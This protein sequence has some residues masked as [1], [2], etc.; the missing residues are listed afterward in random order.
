MRPETPTTAL[1]VQPL[2]AGATAPMTLTFA[3][4]TGSA[5]GAPLGIDYIG[6]A[7]DNLSSVAPKRVLNANIGTTC[8]VVNNCPVTIN[9][10]ATREGLYFNQKRPGNGLA[11]YSYGGGWYT[12]DAERKPTWYQLSG[13]YVD[14]LMRMP[15]RQTFN[16]GTSTNV[17]VGLVERGSVWM[18]RVDPA[19]L[20][21]A[22]QFADGRNG[23]E[24]MSASL[25]PAPRPTVNHTETWFSLNES[26]W[27]LALES[28]ST[29]GSTLEGHGVFIYD[30]AGKP[31]WVL[32]TGNGSNGTAVNLFAYRPHCPGCPWLPNWAA[33]Q[34]PAGT[35]TPTWAG[36][37]GGTVNTAITLPAPLQGTW[38]RT[39]LP[40]IPVLPPAR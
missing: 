19:R 31:R 28:V 36:E 26:G 18:A 14:N 34:A 33:T 23:A 15:L 40:I 13:S 6:S 29:G 30:G 35:L 2:A 37:T 25:A 20:L 22:W 3:V 32:G 38:N 12:A 1:P 24:I 9:P 10:I 16:S 7:A 39:N 8:T 17:A 27:G 21:F 11:A 5:C 4:P